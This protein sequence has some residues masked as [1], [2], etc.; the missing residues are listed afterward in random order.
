MTKRSLLS[1]AL[2]PLLRLCCPHERARLAPV[3]PLRERAQLARELTAPVLT[4]MGSLAVAEVAD[5]VNAKLIEAPKGDQP[6]EVASQ[7]LSE[8]VALQRGSVTIQASQTSRA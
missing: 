6:H 1:L 8:S 7:S 2:H 3:L 4:R 5:V